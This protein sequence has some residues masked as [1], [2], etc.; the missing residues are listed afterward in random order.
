MIAQ[1]LVVIACDIDQALYRQAQDNSFPAP[2]HCAISASTSSTS[3]PAIDDIA[4]QKH[5]FGV[6]TPKNSTS[7]SG[8]HP[9]GPEM[10]IGNEQGLHLDGVVVQREK[11]DRLI[12]MAALKTARALPCPRP[13]PRAAS[14]RRRR[15]Q[16]NA[17]VHHPLV[18]RRKIVRCTAEAS[19]K[20]QTG[21]GRAAR[22]PSAIATP[23]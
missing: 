15:I 7:R 2:H 22:C 16:Q 13:Y 14:P 19:E 18:R 17:A 8:W 11:C 4:D 3:A 10:D 12:F 23:N 6:M 1:E 20:N 5:R 9:P 21:H